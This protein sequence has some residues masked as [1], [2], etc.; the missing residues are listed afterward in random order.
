MINKVL[1]NPISIEHK[2][3]IGGVF[4]KT[5]ITYTLYIKDSLNAEGV[6]FC[7]TPENHATYNILMENVGEN[8][9]YKEYKV[10]FTYVE[11]GLYWYHFSFWNGKKTVFVSKNTIGLG[12]L[13]NEVINWQ[14]TVVENGKTPHWFKGGV[15]YQIMTDRFNN[16]NNTYKKDGNLYHKDWYELPLY[17]K[18]GDDI[19]NRDFFGGNFL[20]IE[21]KL[22]YLKSLNVST[23]Y[24]NPI[25]EAKSNHKYDTG[26]FEK[27]DDCFGGEKGFISLL[28][29]CKKHKIKVILDGVF[30][31]VGMDSKYFNKSNLYKE[32]GAYNSKDSIY[33]HWFTFT[34]YPNEYECWWG[35]K[36]LPNVSENCQTY[37]D[38]ICGKGGIVEKYLKMGVDGFRLD[39][40]D[41]LPDEFLDNLIRRIKKVKKNAIIVG[42]VWEDASS[43]IAYGKRRKY[44]TSNQL[45]GVMNYVWKDGIIDFIKTGNSQKL[46]LQ[47][48]DIINNYPSKNLHCNMNLLGTHDTVRIITKLVT[49]NNL[50]KE[51]EREIKLS[52]SKYEFGRKLL[53]LAAILEYTLPGVPTIYYGDEAGLEGYNDPFNR[54]TFPWEKEDT[55]LQNYYKALGKIRENIEFKEGTLELLPYKEGV[56]AYTRGNKYLTVVN[57][58]GK[59]YQLNGK[60]KNLISGERVFS[61]S[62]SSAGIF[63]KIV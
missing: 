54:R 39:V 11:K 10:T 15:L 9:G 42:E 55:I 35:V 6:H 48:I 47:I 31:H 63:E 26:D 40:V 3:V 34:N 2:S 22:D 13:S 62:S 14:E 1:Y 45:D 25:F 37:I 12:Q 27:I 53:M 43:K 20:G 19:L 49:D 56:I 33:Y 4:E 58:S 28:K 21:K 7:V 38:Y 51:E 8:N 17:E 5:P 59:R 60:Y 46:Y 57:L 52:E 36:L 50:S 41:E 24:L 32:I 16:F 30:N 61:V 18:V 23:I 29:A 44:F